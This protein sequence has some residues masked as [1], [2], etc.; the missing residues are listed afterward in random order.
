MIEALNNS[1]AGMQNA[2]RT[3][4]K[5]ADNI[6]NPNSKTELTEDIVDVQR[7]AQDFKANATVLGM[8]KDMQE[9]LYRA[10]DITV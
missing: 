7:G 5:A 9:E 6:S 2:S 8:T 3:V 1:V 4:A 10:I